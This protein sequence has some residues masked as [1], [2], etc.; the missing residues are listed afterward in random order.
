MTTAEVVCDPAHVTESDE[1]QPGCT[2]LQTVS[3]IHD[4]LLYHDLLAEDGHFP[5]G[6]DHIFGHTHTHTYIL[7]EI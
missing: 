6:W 7:S 2:D 5:E 3:V 4:E 1:Q